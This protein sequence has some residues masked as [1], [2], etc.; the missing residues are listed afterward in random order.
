MHLACSEYSFPAL[1]L[2]KRLEL[3]RLLGFDQASLSLFL[4]DDAAIASFLSDAGRVPD[5]GLDVSDVFLILRGGD[6]AGG[7]INSPDEAWRQRAGQVFERA[8]AYAS[9]VKARAI[10]ILPGTPW[11]EQRD[12]GW[13]LCVEELAPRAALARDHGLLLQIEPHLGSIVST[14]ELVLD[15]LASVPGLGLVLDASHFIV[16]SIAL[17]RIL[18]LARH[19]TMVHVRAARA[20]EIQ[21]AW[22]RNETDFAKLI[23]ALRTAQFTGTLVIEYTPMKQWRCDEMDVLTAIVETRRALT[24]IIGECK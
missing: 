3:V 15:L 16:Q 11:P 8:I 24:K 12:I 2:E 23:E 21:V 10:T 6:F 17:P 1:P 7:A 5:L 14:P 20:G 18:P 19:A 13:R 4:D 9:A 22:E